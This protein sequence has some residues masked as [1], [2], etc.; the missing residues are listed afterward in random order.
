MDSELRLELDYP[1]EPP[2][3][4]QTGTLHS[5]K[6]LEQ[7][8]T[9]SARFITSQ[10]WPAV[11]ILTLSSQ[12]GEFEHVLERIRMLSANLQHKTSGVN[13]LK[14]VFNTFLRLAERGLIA[15]GWFEN[16][17]IDSIYFAIG[18]EFDSQHRKKEVSSSTK[19]IKKFVGVLKRIYS[20]LYIAHLLLLTHSR[21]QVLFH[22]LFTKF[23][24]RTVYN[25]HFFLHSKVPRIFHAT[26]LFC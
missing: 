20:A 1:T 6:T 19:S 4:D 13:N 17:Q 25:L 7:F 22:R 26:L 24:F 21:K 11:R 15:L 10:T 16:S 18:D 12:S 14:V 9:S 8:K 23:F 3:Q 5:S 2:Q